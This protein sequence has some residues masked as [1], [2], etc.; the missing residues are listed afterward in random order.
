M[1]ISILLKKQT[2]KQKSAFSKENPGNGCTDGWLQLQKALQHEQH[3]SICLSCQSSV[4]VSLG[5]KLLLFVPQNVIRWKLFEKSGIDLPPKE[6]CVWCLQNLQYGVSTAAFWRT[7]AVEPVSVITCCTNW[8]KI[9]TSV[10]DQ[11]TSCL[12]P[13]L[14]VLLITCIPPAWVAAE[15]TPSPH[16]SG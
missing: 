13:L 8:G 7:A 3:Y 1:H 10:P 11:E 4:W 16:A 12:H 2:N 15:S 14:S 5:M 9:W 6:A